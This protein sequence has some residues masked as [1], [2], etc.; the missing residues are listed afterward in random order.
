MDP[1]VE[2]LA[3]KLKAEGCQSF[4][5]DWGPGAFELTPNERAQALLAAIWEGERYAVSYD[6]FRCEWWHFDCFAK[7]AA[8]SARRLADKLAGIRNPYRRP[9]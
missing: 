6:H 3:Q 8:A 4:H 5:V 1:Y 2:E 9:A 7:E